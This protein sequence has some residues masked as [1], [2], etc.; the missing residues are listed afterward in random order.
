MSFRGVHAM[1]VSQSP[2]GLSSSQNCLGRRWSELDESNGL[3]ADGRATRSLLALKR[4]RKL[5]RLRVDVRLVYQHLFG[6]SVSVL[7]MPAVPGRRPTF[8]GR[9]SASATPHSC[10]PCP[11]A[12]ATPRQDHCYGTQQPSVSPVACEPWPYTGPGGV[13]AVVPLHRETVQL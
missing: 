7:C 5:L 13:A 3:N 4:Q 6:F 2:P 9:G 8:S 11:P 1:L 12:A 10:P